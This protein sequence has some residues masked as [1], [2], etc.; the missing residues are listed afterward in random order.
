MKQAYTLYGD[1]LKPNKNKSNKKTTAE[2]KSSKAHPVCS[3][4]PR[5]AGKSLQP[6]F[7]SLGL[8]ELELTD[9]ATQ[10]N[11]NH[12]EKPPAK[13]KKRGRKKKEPTKEIPQTFES[14]TDQEDVNPCVSEVQIP[15]VSSKELEHVAN[16]EVTAS[17]TQTSE[18]SHMNEQME[19]T[20]KWTNWLRGTSD[21]EAGTSDGAGDTACELLFA[22]FYYFIL[23]N[24][25][26][27]QLVQAIWSLQIWKASSMHFTK[28][29]KRPP[30]DIC[31]S[32]RTRLVIK[33]EPNCVTW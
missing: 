8:E 17:S 7:N 33:S 25:F 30:W 22:N 26:K 18:S 29:K 4:T 12:E 16:R 27:L 11:K 9:E 3:S 24:Y 2:K 31:V 28:Q 15:S 19:A 21:Y 1:E 10:I 23:I 20:L 32:N 5:D 14:H 6:F 13:A